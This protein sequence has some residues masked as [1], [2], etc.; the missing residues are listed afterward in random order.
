MK[1]PLMEGREDPGVA[2]EVGAG[3]VRAPFQAGLPGPQTSALA[4]RRARQRSYKN[5]GGCTFIVFRGPPLRFITTGSL[6]LP[7]RGLKIVRAS[8]TE[9]R[10]RVTVREH[11][12]DYS[13]K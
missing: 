1:V 4:C 9:K 11:R 13:L 12:G 7:P 2:L 8:Y 3:V 10:N 5:T 6:L